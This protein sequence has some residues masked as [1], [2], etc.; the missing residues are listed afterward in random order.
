MD[1][2]F[3]LIRKMRQGD[4]KAF[5]L[6]IHKYYRDILSYCNYHCVI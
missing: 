3:L 4:E 1:L 6:F 5:D 2:D